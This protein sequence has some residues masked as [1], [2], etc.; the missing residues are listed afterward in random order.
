MAI[1][2]I[3]AVHASA[4]VQKIE[5]TDS[6]QRNPALAS[7]SAAAP[8]GRVPQDRVPKDRVPQDRVTISAAAL[9]KQSASAGDRAHD[10]DSK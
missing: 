8:Q 1:D 9:A 7:Q 10:G 6:A 2:P 4:A 5:A 3:R